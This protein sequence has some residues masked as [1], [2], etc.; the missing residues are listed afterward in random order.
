MFKNSLFL[1]HLKTRGSKPKFIVQT[2]N[3]SKQYFSFIA[4]SK[5]KENGPNGS[6]GHNVTSNAAGEISKNNPLH[7]LELFTWNYHNLKSRM[8]NSNMYKRCIAVLAHRFHSRGYCAY[9]TGK[10][11]E[12]IS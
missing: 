4:L 2:L 6:K 1:P 3:F 11:V 8:E 7:P 5:L 9:C 10:I 12:Q